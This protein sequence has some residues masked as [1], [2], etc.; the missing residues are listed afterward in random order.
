MLGAE[1]ERIE[2]VIGIKLEPSSFEKMS[3][4]HQNRCRNAKDI[5]LSV[6]KQWIVS[7]IVNYL[8]PEMETIELYPAIEWGLQKNGLSEEDQEELQII[9][10]SKDQLQG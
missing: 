8:L 1:I 10:K 7:K 4:L 3:D 2:C 9:D 5:K 6:W